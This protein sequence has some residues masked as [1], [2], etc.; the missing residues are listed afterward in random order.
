MGTCNVLDHLENQYGVLALGSP[1]DG[2][3]ADYPT[4]SMA[5]T[6]VDGLRPEANVEAVTTSTPITV[7]QII[8]H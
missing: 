1:N 6:A 3:K 8:A 2:A 5:L 4:K 7:D